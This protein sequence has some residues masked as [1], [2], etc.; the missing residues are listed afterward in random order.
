MS[1]A[2]ELQRL[3]ERVEQLQAENQRLSGRGT[4]DN[5]SGSSGQTARREQALYLPRERKCHKFSGSTAAGSLAVEEWIEEAQS[6]IR[7]R[8]MS[9]LEKA[10]FLFDHLEGEARNEIKYRPTTVR[11]D[12]QAII[13]VLKEVY[14]CSRSYVFWQQQF[15]DRKQR[16]NESLF[17]FSHALMEL[18][19]RV[20]LSKTDAISNPDIVLRDQFCENVCDPMLRREL[21]RVVRANNALTLLDVRKEAIRWVE[22]GQANRDRSH[23]APG[24]NNE[25]HVAA[26]CATS[27]AQSAEFSELK[28]LVIKQQAQLDM[29]TKRFVQSGGTPQAPQSYRGGRFKRAP[30]GRPICLRCEQPGHIARFCRNNPVSRN[31]GPAPLQPSTDPPSQSL[32]PGRP[33]T[34]PENC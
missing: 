14:G 29:L 1:S 31:G 23:R 25:V 32:V 24:K 8:F 11:E 34:Q 9:D 15:F 27:A 18:I 10:L 12:P 22:E 26:Q 16:E 33:T 28:E 30:D 21:K 13:N 4:G 2:E 7:S 5:G 17:E 3:Q 19:D 20:K 6:C